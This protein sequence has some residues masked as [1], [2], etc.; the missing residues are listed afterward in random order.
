MSMTMLTDLAVVLGV[1]TLALL[2]PGPD[3]MIVVKNSIGGERAL[4]LGTVLGIGAGLVVQM[5]VIGSGLAVLSP[6]AIGG[7]QLAGA[8][9]LAWV[10]VRAVMSRGEASVRGPMA[11]AAGGAAGRRWEAG[12]LRRGF[13][14][15]FGCNVLNP[16]AFLFFVSLLAQ[17]L[18]RHDAPAW[19]LGVPAAIVLHG[20]MCWTLI[21]LALQSRV[22][23]R[24][25]GRAQQWLPRVFGG[26]LIVLAA[27]LL[28]ESVQVLSG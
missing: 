13:F 26:V 16:K 4:A 8:A 28:G 11:A 18:P 20:V 7:V 22:V 19:R 23:A 25:L 14:Q 24:R 17:A 12:A 27:L 3:F 6:L 15:G 5:V 2:S 21:V 10:G 1:L 9:F